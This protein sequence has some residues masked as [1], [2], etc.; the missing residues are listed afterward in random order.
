MQLALLT[1]VGAVL[2]ETTVHRHT[3][4]LEV[5]TEQLITTTAVEACSAQLGVIGDDSLA[6][7][8]VFD[9]GSNGGDNADSFVAGD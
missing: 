6:N 8:E 2:S 3:V 1:R 5:L 9:L 7:L 4:S